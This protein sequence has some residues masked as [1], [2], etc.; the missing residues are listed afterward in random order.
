MSDNIYD[1]VQVVQRYGYEAF[2]QLGLK[3]YR[4]DTQI[5]IDKTDVTSFGEPPNTVECSQAW[6]VGFELDGPSWIDVKADEIRWDHG[7]G[8]Q[9]L[10]SEHATKVAQA[11]HNIRRSLE[12]VGIMTTG[13]VTDDPEYDLAIIRDVL[14]RSGLRLAREDSLLEFAGHALFA[15]VDAA[16]A[17]AFKRFLRPVTQ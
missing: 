12:T 17:A 3:L 9:P 2:A 16:E 10:G 13:N 15:W 11:A 6:R 5:V 1:T 7:P 8:G 14:Q 4:T